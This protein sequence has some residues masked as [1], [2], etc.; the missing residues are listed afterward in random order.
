MWRKM[1]ALRDKLMRGVGT[2]EPFVAED[3][4]ALANVVG[5]AYGRE[6]QAMQWRKPLRIDEINQ[7]APTAEGRERRGRP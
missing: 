1:Q 2:D 6:P 5:S 3:L 4:R 7:L